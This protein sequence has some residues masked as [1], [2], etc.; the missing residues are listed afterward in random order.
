MTKRFDFIHEDGRCVPSDF[1]L[2]AKEIFALLG[3]YA[4]YS[5]SYRRFVM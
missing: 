2:G 1:C 3:R 4:A 5:G